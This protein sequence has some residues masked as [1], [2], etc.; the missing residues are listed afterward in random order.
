M[1]N[2]SVGG[3]ENSTLLEVRTQV[4]RYPNGWLAGWMDHP[5]LG[6]FSAVKIAKIKKKKEYWQYWTNHVLAL[7]VSV[8]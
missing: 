6:P 5:D 1:L 3:I 2:L 4:P 7:A 8:V